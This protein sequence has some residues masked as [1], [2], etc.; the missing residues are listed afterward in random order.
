[1]NKITIHGNATK[2]VE[3]GANGNGKYAHLTIASDRSTK[4]EH[5]AGTDFFK[6]VC[7][8]DWVEDLADIERGAFLKI[9]GSVRTG[10]FDGK[11]TFQIVAKSVERHV[12]EAAQ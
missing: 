9:V 11:P 6:V 12:K 5:A 4:R 1:M 2:D 10:E 3:I 8:G 7:F